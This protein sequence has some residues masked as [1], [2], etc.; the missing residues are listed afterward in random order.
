MANIPAPLLDRMEIIQ[1][2]GYTHEEKYHIAVRHLVPKQLK[3]HGLTQE[4]LHISGDSIKL[5]GECTFHF[6]H[7]LFCRM[8]L[9]F[10][11][12]EQNLKRLQISTV[13]RLADG[14]Y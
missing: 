7:A 2:P 8:F 11:L 3:E 9:S 6:D 1:I 12:N 13:T 5:V 4:Q 14:T 10:T